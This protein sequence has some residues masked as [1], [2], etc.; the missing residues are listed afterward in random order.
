MIVYGT[1]DEDE[2]S[3]R[4]RYFES[5]TE[6]AFGGNKADYK[7]KAKDIEKVGACKVIVWNGGGTVKLAILILN[8]M[9]LL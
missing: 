7:E 9:K 4:E 6:A 3:L 1:E 8:I 5:F 2:E